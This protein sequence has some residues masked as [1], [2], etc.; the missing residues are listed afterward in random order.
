MTGSPSAIASSA[1]ALHNSP[2][3]YTDPIPLIGVRAS[4]DVKDLAASQ[5]LRTIEFAPFAPQLTGAIDVEPG[6]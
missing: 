2:A 1:L 6:K 4:P 3:A 5:W